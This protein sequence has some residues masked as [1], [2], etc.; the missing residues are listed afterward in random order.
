MYSEPNYSLNNQAI[1]QA[2]VSFPDAD[3]A[4]DEAVSI[5]KPLSRL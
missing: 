5:T 3:N 2:V 4:P 1:E